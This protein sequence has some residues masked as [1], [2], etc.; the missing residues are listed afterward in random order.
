[1]PGP[2]TADADDLVCEVD[3][4]EVIEEMPPIGLERVAVVAT[5][6]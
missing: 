5:A 2:D 1:M 3:E 6:R 4:R